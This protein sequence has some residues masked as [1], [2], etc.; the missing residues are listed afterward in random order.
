[1]DEDELDDFDFSCPEC[2]APDPQ[3]ARDG[4]IRCMECDWHS[5]DD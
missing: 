2:G 4:G 5:E 1:M 3:P